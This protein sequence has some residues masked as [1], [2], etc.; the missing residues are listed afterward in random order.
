M[1]E[2]RSTKMFVCQGTLNNKMIPDHMNPLTLM[3]AISNS[4]RGGNRVR[5][6]REM[7]ANAQVLFG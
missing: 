1:V 3:S 6:S 4:N 5:T 2:L 7:A